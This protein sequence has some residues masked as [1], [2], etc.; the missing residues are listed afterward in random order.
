MDPFRGSTR[1]HTSW[2]CFRCLE[3]VNKKSIHKMLT[4][5]WRLKQYSKYI[6]ES[7]ILPKSL[8]VRPQKLPKPERRQGFQPSFFRGKLAVKLQECI[9]ERKRTSQNLTLPKQLTASFTPGSWMA[10]EDDS[11]FRNCGKDGL[12]PEDMGVSKNRG[13]PKMDG[14]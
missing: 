9:T 5:L 4:T 12:F 14:S 13:T 6:F 10:R 3:Q 8:T 1:Q 2:I 7:T 11:I